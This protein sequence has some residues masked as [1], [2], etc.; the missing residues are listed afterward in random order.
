MTPEDVKETSEQVTAAFTA[1]FHALLKKYGAEFEAT[2]DGAEVVIP[3]I[4]N[5]Q[6][7]C[8]RPWTLVELPRWIDGS[9]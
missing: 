5:E 2:E 4:Y 1:D 8:V 9:N 3:A 6:H 7:G